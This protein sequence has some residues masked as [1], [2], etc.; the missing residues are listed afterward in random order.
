MQKA[1]SVALVNSIVVSSYA[2]ALNPERTE[3]VGTYSQG[4]LV[5]PLTFRRATP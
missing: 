2:G 3:L 1:S 4:G 5:A